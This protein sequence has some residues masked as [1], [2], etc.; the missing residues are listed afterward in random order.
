M[1]DIE[2]IKKE[3]KEADEMYRAKID[4]I[5]ICISEIV[6]SSIDVEINCNNTDAQPEV[7]ATLSGRGLVAL[8]EYLREVI[9]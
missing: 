2:Q 5:A 8:K 3:N 9:K 1:K 6:D 4:T 7:E